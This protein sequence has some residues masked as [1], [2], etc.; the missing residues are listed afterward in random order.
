M[1]RYL[2][3]NQVAFKLCSSTKTPLP[4]QETFGHLFHCF[5]PIEEGGFSQ[6]R[7]LP[8]MVPSTQ[9]YEVC[10]PSVIAPSVR[11]ILLLLITTSGH[12]VH[13]QHYT[14]RHTRETSIFIALT[15]EGLYIS[16]RIPGHNVPVNIKVGPHLLHHYMFFIIYCGFHFNFL[17]AV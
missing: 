9:V 7:A 14:Y 11:E 12:L 1:I 4:L 2:S 3:R 6:V 5:S 15:F 16:N 17:T 10:Q 13:Y 8:T